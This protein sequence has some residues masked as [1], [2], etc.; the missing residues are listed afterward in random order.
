M[1]NK[2]VGIVLANKIFEEVVQILFFIK[3]SIFNTIVMIVSMGFK[4]LISGILKSTP[5]LIAL[6]D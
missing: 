4:R 2:P 5:K 1:F 3:E 6:L